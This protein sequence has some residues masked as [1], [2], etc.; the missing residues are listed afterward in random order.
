MSVPASVTH[1]RQ[2]LLVASAACSLIILDTNIVAVSLPSIARDLGAGL[3]DIEWVV[4]AYMLSFASL[5]LPAGS[6]ADRFGRKRL[7][8]GGLA[9]FILASLGCGL[10]PTSLMLDLARAVKGVGAAMLLTSALACIGH[11][12]HDDQQRAKAWAFWGAC[13]GVVITLAPVTGGVITATVGWRWIF[14][15]NLPIG[16]ALMWAVIRVIDES[17]DSQAARLDPWGSLTFSTSLVLLVWGLIEANRI[18]WE[19]PS[20]LL[21]LAAGAAMLGGFVWVE[22]V[23]RRPMVDLQLFRHP[24]FIGA[25]LG[26]FAY[27][28]TAQVMMTLLPFYLQNGLGFSTIASGL[29]MLPFALAMLVCPRIGAR[30]APHYS[31]ATMTAIGLGLVGTGNL[32]CAWATASGR[33]EAFA[34]AMVVTGAG[35]G[36]LNGD[37]QKNIMMC[38][39]R[40]RV[41]MGSGMST[42][43]RF[44]S[45]L[46]AFGAYGALLSS[47]LHQALTMA[48]QGLLPA[49]L[50]VAEVATRVAAGDL[51]SVLARLPASVSAHVA[52]WAP[53]AFRSAFHSVLVAAGLA[54]LLSSV[55]VGLL[56]RKPLPI[57]RSQ[58]T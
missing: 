24:R 48:L 12:F 22:K 9:L 55:A 8:L 7:L 51:P 3:A 17:A 40:D 5:L 36:L 32:L 39:P 58:P 31:P 30:L 19:N 25:L 11:A 13:M 45:I 16:L 1:P 21:R 37:S 14:L 52:E 41:G 26:M 46:L 34:L 20:T 27:A 10:A 54:A 4:S 6:L 18:G 57:L 38:I 47:Q 23:Q 44:S 28:G 53:L 42:T 29:G 50:P 49:S 56:L 43:M 33:Y 2:T 15:L 35:A